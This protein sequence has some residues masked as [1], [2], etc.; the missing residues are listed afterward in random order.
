MKHKVV[1]L[2]DGKYDEGADP[3]STTLITL[4]IVN[5]VACGYLNS[6]GYDGDQFH[7]L[8]PKI[9]PTKKSI[10]VTKRRLKA[11]QQLLA[12]AHIA[13]GR[14]AASAGRLFNENDSFI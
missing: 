12:E 8:A 2:A 4:E 11:H 14:F 10:A 9:N 3:L 13:G 1:I 6:L 7:K 5:Q